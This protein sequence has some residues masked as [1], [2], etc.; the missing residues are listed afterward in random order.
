MNTLAIYF[1]SI[2]KEFA[3][4]KSPDQAIKM[5]QYMKGHFSF[6]GIPSPKRKSIHNELWKFVEKADKKDYLLLIS[7]LYDLPQRE[8]QYCALDILQAEFKKQ[9][10]LEDI[11]FLENLI[12]TKSWWDSVDAISRHGLGVYSSKFPNEI[13]KIIERFSENQ[14]LWLNR[15]CLLFQLGYK[16]KT[17]QVLLFDLCIYFQEHDDFFIKKAIGWALREYA[18]TNPNSVKRFVSTHDLSNLSKREAL[19]NLNEIGY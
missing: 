14:N 5:Q 9:A 10:H 1:E 17:D 11:K 6:L 7:K 18:K 15:S 3:L 16:E 19:K 2:Q 12:T 13:P 8:F 4:L